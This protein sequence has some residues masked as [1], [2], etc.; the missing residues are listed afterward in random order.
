MFGSVLILPAKVIKT[1]EAYCR[2][3]IWSGA[4]TITKKALVS[5]EK[6]CLPCAAGGFQLTNIKIWHKAA[7]VK[8]CWDPEH[9]VDQIDTCLL[10]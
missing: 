5:W 9:K 10:H 4:N 6:M 7:I 8:V 2:S 1:I 3:F